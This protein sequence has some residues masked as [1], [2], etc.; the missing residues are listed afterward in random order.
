M[1]LKLLMKRIFITKYRSASVNKER[2]VKDYGIYIGSNKE[3]I[4]QT[5]HI[6]TL[7]DKKNKKHHLK[8]LYW[9]KKEQDRC[10]IHLNDEHFKWFNNV[11]E[12]RNYVAE[13]YAIESAHNEIVS[14]GC[15]VEN[16][17][18]VSK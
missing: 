16:Y 5:L 10:N 15:V 7:D 6:T 4:K 13:H 18:V 14:T 17:V 1:N 2:Y 3:K 9:P 12:A 11:P 8:I